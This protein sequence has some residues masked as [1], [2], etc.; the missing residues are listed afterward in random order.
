MTFTRRPPAADN[1]GFQAD[2]TDEPLNHDELP[3]AAAS[4]LGEPQLLALD[5]IR[6][7]CHGW[8][9]GHIAAWEH[10]HRLA[11]ERLGP[12]EGSLLVARVFAFMRTVLRERKRGLRFL[13]AGCSRICPDEEEMM[14]ALQGAAYQDTEQLYTAIARLVGN[15]QPE[16]TTALAAAKALGALFR[17][18][19]GMW[20]G[21]VEETPRA[22]RMLN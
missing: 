15:P 18:P 7:F 2:E 16:Q 19:V 17:S 12:L 13:S 1:R 5:V 4:G 9:D 6:C 22:R 14:R 11:D 21:E 20:P 3:F 10:A 8:A